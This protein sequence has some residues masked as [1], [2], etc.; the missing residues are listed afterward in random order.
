[1]GA[2]FI[3]GAN[4]DL[5]TGAAAAIVFRATE[6]DGRLDSY[7]IANFDNP[8]KIVKLWSQN[9]EIGRAEFTPANVHDITLTASV[10]G[11]RV[12][13]YI[14]GKE[15]INAVLAGDEP[16]SGRFG[17]NACATRAT[18]KSVFTVLREYE[19]AEGMLEIGAGNNTRI[20]RIVNRTFG[21][22]EVPS[23]F[24]KL[25][26]G[27]I[28]I[29]NAYLSV[30]PE[31]GVYEFAVTGDKISYEITVDV[32]ALPETVVSST[33]V[34]VG[35]DATV[36]IGKRTTEYVLVN[37][38][39][40][41]SSAYEIKNYTIKISNSVLEVGDNTVVLSD[42]TLF[43]VSVLGGDKETISIYIPPVPLDFTAVSI[44]MGVTCGLILLLLIA[45]IVLIVLDRKKKITLKKPFCDRTAAVRRRNFGLIVGACIAGPIALIFAVC[46]STAPI[47]MGGFI[48]AAVLTVVF[49][50]PYVAQLPWKGKIYSATLSPIKTMGT[51]KDIFDVDKECN[52]FK[53]V[54]R[55]IG[56]AF[57]TLWLGI[58]ILLCAVIALIRAPFLFVG[59]IKGVTYGE[60]GFSNKA[61]SIEQN[62]AEEN[63][64]DAVGGEV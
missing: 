13:I 5:G 60:F 10:E 38:N 15:V 40:I 63:V 62:D 8:G 51:P 46:A 54:L 1:S 20:D 47:G 14:D 41:P 36:F 44:G 56:A 59:Q 42:G 4:F 58:R 9:R 35:V 12:K 26:G 50:Y 2:D 48:A 18:F 33:T 61:D 30:L 31:E 32:K 43:I 29:D 39:A 25:I 24:Y 34:A 27:K 3:Y 11:D 23:G 53:L 49:G 7:I 28:Y 45:F 55:Y 16:K 22:S 21:N 52:K 19:Y 57:K 64:G 6:K 37:S 17:L